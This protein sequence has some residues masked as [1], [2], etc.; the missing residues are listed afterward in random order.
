MLPATKRCSACGSHKPFEAFYRQRLGKY[1]RRANCKECSA[2]YN[3]RWRE[4]NAERVRE[5]NRIYREKHRDSLGAYNRAWNAANPAR[6]RAAQRRYRGATDEPETPVRKRAPKGTPRDK[7][8]IAAQKRAWRLANPEKVRAHKRA[9][10]ERHR[11]QIIARVRQWVAD[12]PEGRRAQCL[13]RRSL[14]KG[15]SGARYT[16][17]EHIQA[18]WDLYGGRCYYCG[19]EAASTDHRIPLARGGSHWPANLVPCCRSCNSR[20]HDRSESVYREELASL[21][22]V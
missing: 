22:R 7:V 21:S 14:Q 6:V 19:A 5:V 1:G 12:N 15:A 2:T 4:E 18:R 17:A 3:N 11:E 16:T 20:K 8:K 13:K 10:H 9:H